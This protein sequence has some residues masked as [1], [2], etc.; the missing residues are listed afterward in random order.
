MAGRSPYAVANVL[1]I[2]KYLQKHGYDKI[3]QSG[4]LDEET[5]KTISAFQLHFRL[6]DISGNADAETEAII[7]ALVGNYSN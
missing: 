1:V 2:Q 4:K 7:F 3:P 6:T 5:R